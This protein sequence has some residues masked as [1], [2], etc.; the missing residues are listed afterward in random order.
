[1]TYAASKPFL[2]SERADTGA[3]FQTTLIRSIIA[4]ARGGAD[5]INIA[6][7]V[8]PADR[9]TLDYLERAPTTPTSTATTNVP[10]ATIVNALV[11]LLGPASAVGNIFKRCLNLSFGRASAINVADVIASGTG[12]SFVTQGSP[13]P[14]RQ[15]AFVTEQ[16]TPR[17]IAL[18]TVATRE[19]I[20]GSDA[21]AVLSRVLA[22][23]L[24]LDLNR[25]CST[26]RQAMRRG[27]P[28]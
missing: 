3:R 17:K 6:K 22:A 8:W 5:A 25:F 18:G 1:M 11:P 13:F 4:V 23:D 27:Q 12:V 20:E 19:L 10:A 26:P 16:L 28:V 24:T 9:S 7:T 2:P 14:V 15:L 21:E